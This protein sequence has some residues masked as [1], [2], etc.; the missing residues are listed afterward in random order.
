VRAVAAPVFVGG[1]AVAALGVSGPGV[2]VETLAGHAV[3]LA[4]E[5]T[6]AI[7]KDGV[8]CT[9]SAGASGIGGAGRV[10]SG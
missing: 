8:G 9:N 6:A 3:V 1:E 7:A 10:R 4:G 5:L 2:K